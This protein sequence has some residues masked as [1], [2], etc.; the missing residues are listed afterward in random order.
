VNEPRPNDVERASATPPRTKRR[1]RLRRQRD[2]E[3]ASAVR[4]L[5]PLLSSRVATTSHL[6]SE[7]PES[8]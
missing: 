6:E 3:R 4:A 5:P 7:V 8:R 2:K 1:L